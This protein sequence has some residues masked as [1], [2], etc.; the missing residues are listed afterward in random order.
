MIFSKFEFEKYIKHPQNF[1]APS[2]REENFE[3]IRL[4]NEDF[5]SI[6]KRFKKKT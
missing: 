1:R 3:H 2:A 5:Y 4:H 6:L